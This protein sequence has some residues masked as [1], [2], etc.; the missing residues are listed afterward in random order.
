FVA[1]FPRLVIRRGGVSSG[2]THVE[3]DAE[4]ESAA[5]Q[6]AVVT[7][8][9]IFKQPGA[10]RGASTVFVHEVEP[11]WK[12]LD[13]DDVFVLETGDKI[14]V[15]Q[16]KNC[17]PMEKAKAAQVVADLTLAKHIDTEVLSQEEARS[18]VVV[19]LLAGEDET[20]EMSSFHAPRPISFRGGG[21]QQQGP[22]AEDSPSPL[23]LFK[24]SD[25]SGQLRFE[26]V[27]EGGPISR[28]EL[29][30]NDVFVI[31][32]GKTLWAWEGKSASR[33]ERASWLKVA[34]AYAR[35]VFE[36]TQDADSTVMPVART[37]QG[38]ESRS[39]L[40]AIA[41]K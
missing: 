21:A 9:R 18:R 38:H 40:R 41:A 20:V 24:L 33:K 28:T 22:D 37:A 16:G 36:Q 32:T 11:T 34:S 29:S 13:D 2:F 14:W 25:E 4:A 27:K 39:F 15:W 7:L 19:R 6:R 10:G 35:H 17:S 12:S 3:T 31:D 1:L 30:G 26:L 8:L 5:K 23:K